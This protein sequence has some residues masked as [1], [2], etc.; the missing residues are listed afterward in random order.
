MAEAGPPRPERLASR[1]YDCLDELLH[2]PRLEYRRGVGDDRRPLRPVVLVADR[3]ALAGAGL[4][5]HFVAVLAQF[6]HPGG[7]DR[8]PVLVGLDLGGDSN[9]HATSSL[10]RRANQNS[11]RSWAR[12][13]SRPVSS[14]TLRIR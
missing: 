6:A 9:L 10:A 5:Q 12:E 8:D 13:R 2:P 4:D 3:A 11:M 14:S 1:G 7:G